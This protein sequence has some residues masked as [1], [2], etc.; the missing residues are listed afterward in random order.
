MPEISLPEVKLPKFEL[1]EGLRDMTREDI[2]KAMPEFRLPNLQKQ[3]E[4]VAENAGKFAGDVG[5][6]IDQ[7][8]PRRP[9][10]SPVPF[11]VLG[12][13]GGL[14]VGWLLATSPSTSARINGF[15]DWARARIDEWRNRTSSEFEDE[16]E[17][18]TDEFR[19]Y[20]SGT[21]AYAGAGV[22][23]TETLHTESAGDAW[24]EPQGDTADAWT[25]PQPAG[26]SATSTSTTDEFRDK[27]LGAASADDLPPTDDDAVPD[28]VIIDEVVVVA[29][30]SGDTVTGE[31]SGLMTEQM[32]IDDTEGDDAPGVGRRDAVDETVGVNETLE[33]GRL[34][35]TMQIDDTDETHT[36]R[37]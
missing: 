20:G 34:T 13:V 31:G 25:E 17:T 27:S 23:T 14:V 8:L 7:A 10:P 29:P 11:A 2:Q 32:Q 9:G 18:A 22:G 12:M 1:P 19:S 24:R 37:S 26:T 36:R 33:G 15:M 35:D 30:S 28:A 5:R 4:K 21:D 16:L 3:A 6:N